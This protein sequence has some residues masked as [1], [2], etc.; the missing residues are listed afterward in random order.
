MKFR[1]RR[2]RLLLLTWVVATVI[3][4]LVAMQFTMLRDASFDTGWLLVAVMLVLMSYN[5]RKKLPVLPLGSASGWFQT[6]IYVGLIAA[7]LFFLHVGVVLPSGRFETLLW[8]VFMGL[9]L[10]GFFGLAITRLVPSRLTE[11]GER[12]IYE[13]IPLFRAELAGEAEILVSRSVEETA[14]GSIAGY[15]S[16]RLQGYF[17]R[18]RNF[19][20]HILGSN[21]ATQRILGDLKSLERYLPPTGREILGEI[22]ALVVA[23]DNL[24][25]QH[26]WQKLLK[27]WLF[28]HVPLTHG[29]VVLVVVHVIL[30]HAF[31]SSS[32]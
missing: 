7:L 1:Q 31:A 21:Q 20:L 30:V 9:L 24:D 4:L 22:E 11:R 27:V 16:R 3:V 14:L 29:A 17:A 12:L 2:Y 15:Y 32:P 26:A 10:S 18:P 8:L 23:K 13:R 28:L 6:H 19:W 25:F 5:L